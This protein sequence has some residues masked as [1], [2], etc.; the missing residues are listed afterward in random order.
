MSN[1]FPISDPV[2]RCLTAEGILAQCDES[3]ARAKSLADEIRALEAADEA[4]LTW[5]ST[6][7]KLDL[8]SQALQESVAIPQLI[9]VTHPEASVRTAAEGCEPKAS[10]FSTAFYLDDALATVFKR[11]ERTIKEPTSVQ[12]LFIQET[13]REYRRNGLELDAAG[14]SK[15]TEINETITHLGQTFDK[16]LA[17]AVGAIEIKPEQLDG[18]PASFRDNHPA[19][20]NG[21]VRIT[22]NYPDLVPFMRYAKDRQAARELT[23]LAQNRAADKNLTLLD[24]LIAL[25]KQKATLLGYQTWADYVV[26]PRMAKTSAN[27]RTF[28]NDLHEK[29]RPLAQKEFV[30]FQDMNEQLFGQ[31]EPVASS[32]ASYLEDHICQADFS[33]DSQK[34]SEYFE[35]KAVQQGI[36][37]VAS[38]LYHISFKPVDATRW[39]TDVEVYEVTDIETGALLGRAHID[40]YP[41]DDKYKHAGVFPMRDTRRKEDGSR[42]IPFAALVCNFPK[43]GVSPSLLSHGEVT[44]FFHEFGHLLH[45]L[46]SQS[47]LLSYAGTK[48]AWDF[49][50]APSQMFEAWAWD[51]QTLDLFAKHHTTGELIPQDLF[52]AMTKARLFGEATDTNRQLYFASYDQACHTREPGFSTDA[53]IEE[54]YPLF[55]S[56]TRI[57]NTHFQASFGHLVGYDAAYY[58]YQW[59]LSIAFDLLTRFKSEGMLNEKTAKDYRE[60]IL[61]KGG[62]VEASKLVEQFLGRPTTPDAY[63]AFLGISG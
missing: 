4:L 14:R 21:L 57:P 10:S 62:T 58:S 23:T 45:C 20:E 2:L 39:H 49:V 38:R 32:D 41:R 54:L 15:L 9:A 8:L 34:L 19:G 33:F 16:N 11:A 7:G 6:F 24:E 37:D 18:L 13:L 29:L 40:L 43:P 42:E 26:E 30:R 1:Q 51:R 55:S 36:F 52:E 47:E 48:V 25:R 61:A 44:T 28:L 27:V 31:R 56:F 53:L 3:L 46:L 35:I 59:A 60:T 22:T 50:E 17:E 63:A 5:E 12:K